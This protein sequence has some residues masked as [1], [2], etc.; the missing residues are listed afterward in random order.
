M[1][2][3]SIITGLT[4]LLIFFLTD[5]N[6]PKTIKK[7]EPPIQ[8]GI[9]TPIHD[10][11]KRQLDTPEALLDCYHNAISKGDMEQIALCLGQ[12]STF[13]LNFKKI[14]GINYKIISKI[15]SNDSVYSNVIDG[16][17]QPQLRGIWMHPDFFITTQDSIDFVPGHSLFYY[18]VGKVKGSWIIMSHSSEIDS[19]M[20]EDELKASENMT[21]IWDSLQHKTTDSIKK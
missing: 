9:S 21:R 19:Q 17:F 8:L 3:N 1:N 18:W 13:G 12:K 7:L 16:Y 14:S 11:L 5:C 4:L 2:T 10:S 20:A 15:K 6:Q